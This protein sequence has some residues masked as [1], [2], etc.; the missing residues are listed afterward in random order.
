MKIADAKLAAERKHAKV[1]ER[2]ETTGEC[3]TQFAPSVEN[4]VVVVVPENCRFAQIDIGATLVA[5]LLVWREPVPETRNSVE[6][7][8][9]AVL[10]FPVVDELRRGHELEPNLVA[11]AK[12]LPQ[13]FEGDGSPVGNRYDSVA[14]VSICL[15]E[16]ANLPQFD[17]GL[18]A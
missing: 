11:A 15:V 12:K 1:A 18:Y 16:N 17:L 14:C 8:K 6:L 10:S 7:F 9:P 2:V 4:H 13:V 3:V 5:T